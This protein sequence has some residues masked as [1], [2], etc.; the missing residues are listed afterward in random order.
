LGENGKG[1]SQKGTNCVAQRKK[2]HPTGGTREI[3]RGKR[4]KKW[5]YYLQKTK[6]EDYT[7]GFVSLEMID[8]QITKEKVP[9]GQLKRE[10][11]GKR[12]K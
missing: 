8:G 6:F 12:G 9:E 1:F 5:S 4:K 11:R 7:Q 2:I 3:G 10:K